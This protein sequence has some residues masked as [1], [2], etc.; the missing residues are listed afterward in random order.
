MEENVLYRS[1]TYNKEYSSEAANTASYGD[2][3]IDVPGWYRL[4]EE[5][6]AEARKRDLD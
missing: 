1:E 6:R 2:P 5:L 3:Q 4:L